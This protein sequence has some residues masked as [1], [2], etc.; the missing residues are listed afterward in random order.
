MPSALTATAGD[1]ATFVDTNVLVYA[2]DSFDAAKQR[3]AQAI[4]E[5][6]WAKGTGVLSAQ[7]L[8]EFYSVATSRQKRAMKPADAREIVELYSA[9]P[10]VV[11]GSTLILNA[12]GLHEQQSVSFWD[13]LIVEAARVAGAKRILSED[14]QHGGEIAGVRIENPFNVA[15]EQAAQPATDDP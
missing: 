2:Y 4:L 15:S 13:A 14:L 12:S 1:S 11:I 10:V 6:L 9:W 7:V 5:E 8:Q 3:T